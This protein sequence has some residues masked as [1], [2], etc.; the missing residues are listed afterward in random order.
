MLLARKTRTQAKLTRSASRHARPVDIR[1]VGKSLKHLSAV[2]LESAANDLRE[3]SHRALDTQEEL[4]TR[5]LALSA[6]A[7]RRTLGVGLYD[8]QLLA[9][10]ALSTNCVVEMETGEGKTFVAAVGAILGALLGRPAHVST[11][12]AYLAKRDY[13][14]LLPAFRALGISAGLLPESEVTD[15]K[16]RQAYECDVTYGTGYEFGFDYLRDQLAVRPTSHGPLGTTLLKRLRGHEAGQTPMQPSHVLAIVDEVDN[17][18]LDDADSPLVLAEDCAGPAE[19]SAACVLARKLID[20]LHSGSHYQISAGSQVRLT[21][22]GISAIHSPSVGV[23]TK[24]LRRPWTEYVEH[25]IRADVLFQRDSEYVVEN[26]EIKIVDRSTG[27]IFKDRTWSEGLHQAIEAKEGLSISKEQSVLAQVTRQRYYQLYS[28]RCGM[29]GTAVGCE[30]EFH[31]VY[32][33]R[34]FKVPRRVESQRR[35][36]PMRTFADSFSKWKAILDETQSLHRTSRPVLIGTKTI[37]QSERIADLLQQH[38][39]PFQLLNG[40]QD[41]IE[42]DIISR[43][44]RRGAITIATNLAGRGTDIRLS[45]DAQTSGGLHVIVSEPHDLTRIDRQLVGRCARQGDPGSARTF[46]S[47]EDAFVQDHAPWLA[48]PIVKNSD[49]NHEVTLDLSK[50]IVSVQRAIEKR[51]AHARIMLMRQDQARNSLMLPAG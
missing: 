11:P 27:R 7:I 31:H 22:D 45:P 47:A 5:A 48:N 35:L 28:H 3:S 44:G 34:V 9:A 43:A 24:E 46:L 40:K 23:P 16:K 13:E 37:V 49:S 20:S 33:M 6:E 10:S 50:R 51:Q 14:Q 17:V 30:A 15:E 42:A 21:S 26:D 2:E 19:D 12:N 32:A 18:L 29:T 4:A 39:L 36:L 1:R 38:Q 41:A 8:V 25:A